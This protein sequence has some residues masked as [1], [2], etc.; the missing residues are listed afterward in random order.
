M[1]R[2]ASLG[3]YFSLSEVAGNGWRS[4]DA[5][6]DPDTLLNM[7]SRTRKAVAASA[8]CP[9]ERIPL[10]MAAS[11]FHIGVAARLLS[12]LIG[13]A[14]REFAV[15]VL[16]A[17]SLLWRS[18]EHHC[19]QF[20]VQGLG[21]TEAKEVDTAAA[22]MSA[23]V[24]DEVLAPMGRAIRDATG[25]SEKVTRGNVISSANGSVTVLAMR[26]PEYE[27]RGRAVITALLESEYLHGT[28]YFNNSQFHRRSCCLF[29]TGPHAGLCGDCVLT[30]S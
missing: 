10:R 20:G 23:S 4:W 24:I 16:K 28:G 9:E 18:T 15:P 27:Q 26:H 3:D 12:P 7:A 21:C 25:L 22:A 30:A 29:Y 1:R 8:G 13:A 19:P 2:T 6:L 11:S 14:V 17:E 5:L